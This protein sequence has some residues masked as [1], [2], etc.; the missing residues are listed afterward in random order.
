VI[1]ANAETIAA[2]ESTASEN[3]AKLEEHLTKTLENRENIS[4]NKAE[5]A[6]RRTKIIANRAMIASNRAKI[7]RR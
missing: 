1:S 6:E 5:I 4:K 2:L 3:S 7:A